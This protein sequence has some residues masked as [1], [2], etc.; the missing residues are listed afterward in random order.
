MLEPTYEQDSCFFQLCCSLIYQT[1]PSSTREDTVV[2]NAMAPKVNEQDT[3]TF[4][5]CYVGRN[6]KQNQQKLHIHRG[7]ARIFC[8]RVLYRARRARENFFAGTTLPNYDVTESL[9]VGVADT[10]D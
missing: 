10:K 2:A 6:D 8:N 5:K 3:K 7:I 9:P 4:S 1:V